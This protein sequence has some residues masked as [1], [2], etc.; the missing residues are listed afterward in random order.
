MTTAIFI[1]GLGFLDLIRLG[2]AFATHLLVGWAYIWLGI[3][4]LPLHPE[5]QTV[6][7]NPFT[8]SATASSNQ[9]KS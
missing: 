7:S 3:T 5:A 9:K 8:P 6:K 1:Y 4:R 2:V